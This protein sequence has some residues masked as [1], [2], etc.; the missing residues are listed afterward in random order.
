VNKTLVRYHL[1]PISGQANRCGAS[2]GRCPFGPEEEHYFTGK[3]ARTAYELQRESFSKISRPLKPVQLALKLELPAKAPHPPWLKAHGEVQRNLWGS[4][5][6]PLGSISS[7]AGNLLALW[8]EHSTTAADAFRQESGTVAHRITLNHEEHGEELG[9][10]SL[11][12]VTAE[13]QGDRFGNDRW[14][15]FHWAEAA[16]SERLGFLGGDATKDAPL[17]GAL[18]REDRLR[19]KKGLWHKAHLALYLV[20]ESA[21]SAGVSDFYRLEEAHAPESE[22]VLDRELALANEHFQSQRESYLRQKAIPS[23]S[24]IEVSEGLRG[25]GFGQVLYVLA[26]RKL[27]EKGLSLKASENQTARARASWRRMQSSG[28]PISIVQEPGRGNRE[29]FLL[30]FL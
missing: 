30:S 13:S 17:R 23:P 3:E 20:P 12:Y 22:E 15:G 19:L 4:S 5:P 21:S 1:N 6:E 9:A 28:L 27:A 16:G 11:N 18:S 25:E 8:E 7:P 2:L 10:L 26:A 29:A 24:Y 14:S